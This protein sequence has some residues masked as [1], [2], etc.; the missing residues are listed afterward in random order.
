MT[1]VITKVAIG[2]V[3]YPFAGWGSSGEEHE[4]ITQE[5]YDQ[6][7]PAQ[8]AEKVYM[9]T[10]EGTPGGGWTSEDISYDNT[11]SGLTADNVQDAI[12]EIAQGIPTPWLWTPTLIVSDSSTD[13]T[14]ADLSWYNWFLVCATT[15][16]ICYVSEL[17]YKDFLLLGRKYWYNAN[18]TQSYPAGEISWTALNNMTVKWIGWWKTLSVYWI[19]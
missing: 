3:E 7:T 15:S 16:S 13:G 19:N 1:D 8:K 11:T 17:I 14:V 6:L 4:F 12:D 9:I 2:W 10:G 18:G 5:E